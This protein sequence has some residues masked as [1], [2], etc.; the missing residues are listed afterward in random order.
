MVMEKLTTEQKWECELAVYE[1]KAHDI[2]NQL[3]GD[4]YKVKEA[5]GILGSSV[6]KILQ[7]MTKYKLTEKQQQV[8]GRRYWRLLDET[9]EQTMANTKAKPDGK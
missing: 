6:L 5:L 2:I 8:F 3:S 4:D 9:L 1:M 7:R